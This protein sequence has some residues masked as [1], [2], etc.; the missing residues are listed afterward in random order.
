MPHFGDWSDSSTSPQFFYL[1]QLTILRKSARK[2]TS[3]AFLISAQQLGNGAIVE[4]LCS[5]R[6]FFGVRAR[7]EGSKGY[8]E[9]G[10]PTKQSRFEKFGS[11]RQR[12]KRSRAINACNYPMNGLMTWL[13]AATVFGPR[14]FPRV[15]RQRLPPK[16]FFPRTLTS[17]DAEFCGSW[18]NFMLVKS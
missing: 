13:A 11:G 3:G 4:R 16:P 6:S 1:Q 8:A 2:G 5:G 18:L 10:T 9:K 15:L 17:F 12:L 7:G 14:N